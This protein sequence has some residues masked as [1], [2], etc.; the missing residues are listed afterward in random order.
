MDQDIF[1]RF[2]RLDREIRI[3]RDLLA[4]LDSVWQEYQEGKDEEGDSDTETVVE[5]WVNPYLTPPDGFSPVPEY[6]TD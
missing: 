2:E 4:E 6:L 3:T 1:E 5:E